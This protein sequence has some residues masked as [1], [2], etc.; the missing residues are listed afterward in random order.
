VSRFYL[1]LGLLSFTLFAAV[2]LL[3]RAQPYDDHELRALLMPEGCEMPCFMGIRPGVTMVDEAVKILENSG[4]VKQDEIYRNKDSGLIWQVTWT[5]ASNAPYV[6]TTTDFGTLG[7]IDNVVNEIYIPTSVPLGDI[8]MI[9]GIPPD[10]ILEPGTG[11]KNTPVLY[12][13]MFYADYGLGIESDRVVCPYFSN[14]LESRTVI[15][16]I[17][18][19]DHMFVLDESFDQFFRKRLFELNRRNCKG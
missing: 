16:F 14:L 4:W 19:Q 12:A 7:V 15:S 17:R 11:P 1:K 18:A 2:L 10:Y 9:M 3:I 8:W 6:T 13:Y 5:W